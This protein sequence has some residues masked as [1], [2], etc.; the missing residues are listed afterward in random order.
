MSYDSLL[1]SFSFFFFFF[2]FNDTATT[3]IYTL[4]LHDALLDLRLGL[5]DR[6]AHLGG[7]QG[8]EARL[9][10]PQHAGDRTHERRPH[11]QTGLAPGVARGPGARDSGLDCGFVG[12]G[13]R[14]QLPARGRI[15]GSQHW[16]E[17]WHDLICGPGIGE[18]ARRP[19]PRRPHRGRPDCGRWA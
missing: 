5:N 17:S 1:F 13:E 16:L 8:R 4:S 2:F 19:N 7:E 15:D 11:A 3:E 12:L 6:L 14:G 18:E 10:G 9:V